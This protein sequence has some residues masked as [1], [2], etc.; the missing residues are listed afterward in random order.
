MTG[1]LYQILDR[2]YKFYLKKIIFILEYD[3]KKISPALSHQ[4]AMNDQKI[5]EVL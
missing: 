4:A 1:K 3:D 5:L 2:N